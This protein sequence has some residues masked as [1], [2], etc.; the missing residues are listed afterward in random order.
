MS[1]THLIRV[2]DLTVRKAGNPIV[3]LDELL[4]RP[5]ERLSIE[6]PNGC[7]KT[8]LMRVLAGL[9]TEFEGTCDCSMQPHARILVHQSPYLF[10]GAVMDNVAYGLVAKGI[11]SEQRLSE[12]ENWLRRFGL[13]GF[14]SR[15]VASL[16]GGERRRVALARACILKPQL[17]LLD[18]PLAEL[19]VD[20]ATCLRIALDS[21]EDSAV[22]IASP[23]RVPDELVN[24]RVKLASNSVV[25]SR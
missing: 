15:S 24:A 1:D 7:G 20:G 25:S 2:R 14:A 19:D 21:L 11:S 4:I 13:D 23:T 16:S 10:R 17:L 6:G 5:A 18:E 3:Q 9:E 12:V 22:V 8:T